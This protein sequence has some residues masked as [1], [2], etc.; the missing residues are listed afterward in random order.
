M[1]IGKEEYYLNDDLKIY[2][3]ENFV[4]S[5][6]IKIHQPTLGEIADYGE[7]DYYSMIYN[8]TAT[9]QSLKAQLWLMDHPID[10]TTISPYELFYQMLYRMYDVNQTK[11]LLV[12]IPIKNSLVPIIK[13]KFYLVIWI[14]ENF[15]LSKKKMIKAFCSFR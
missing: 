1:A 5:K 11:I 4:V 15:K 12:Y 2:R 9:P 7:R 8:L 10:Y 14:L 6:Y 13:Q 3:G